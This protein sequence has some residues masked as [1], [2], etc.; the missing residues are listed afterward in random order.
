MS[1]SCRRAPYRPSTTYIEH[2][3][4]VGKVSIVSQVGRRYPGVTRPIDRVSQI[5]YT[6]NEPMTRTIMNNCA[7]SRENSRLKDVISEQ[8]RLLS[9]ERSRRANYASTKR[10]S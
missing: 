1:S 6:G 7:N 5:N 10:S 4:L 8:D 2:R 3:E 9:V